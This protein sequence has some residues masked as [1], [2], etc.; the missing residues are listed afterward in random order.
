MA[1]MAPVRKALTSGLDMCLL[2]GDWGRLGWGGGGLDSATVWGRAI[3][4]HELCLVGSKRKGGV[5]GTHKSR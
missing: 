4:R 2:A 3:V 5:G 1:V